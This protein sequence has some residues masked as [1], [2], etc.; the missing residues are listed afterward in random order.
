MWGFLRLVLHLADHAARWYIVRALT[1]AAPRHFRDR[2]RRDANN[3]RIPPGMAACTATIGPDP[4]NVRV[5]FS[6]A[7]DAGQLDLAHIFVDAINP[8]AAANV[9]T[10]GPNVIDLT[11]AD[12]VNPAV[13]GE[14]A[15]GEMEPFGPNIV[16]VLSRLYVE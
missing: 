16:G 5:T 10:E 12:P 13:M 7:L 14:F 3:L 4:A 9:P 8:T 15:L 11:F 2:R 6:A 1:M